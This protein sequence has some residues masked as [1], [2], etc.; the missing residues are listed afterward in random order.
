ARRTGALVAH[1]VVV[2]GVGGGGGQQ[3]QHDDAGH[4]QTG[5]AALQAQQG[6]DRVRGHGSPSV[7]SVGPGV[8]GGAPATPHPPT[9]PHGAAPPRRSRPRGVRRPPGGGG[10][11]PP[12][13][14]GP[15]PSPGGRVT[16][17]GAAPSPPA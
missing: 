1:R 4:G 2:A 14:G 8:G 11:R 6:G 10:P 9:P 13:E 12:G 3:G 17:T 7:T 5:E 16:R 15:P